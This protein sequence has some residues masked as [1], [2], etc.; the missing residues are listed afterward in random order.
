MQPDRERTERP[1]PTETVA[2]P[3]APPAGSAGVTV[4]GV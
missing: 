2:G 3:F 4:A 1:R